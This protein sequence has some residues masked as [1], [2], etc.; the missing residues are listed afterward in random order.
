M[1]IPGNSFYNAGRP[2]FS[3]VGTA[4]KSEKNNA[5]VRTQLRKLS[6]TADSDDA[7]GAYLGMQ[8]TLMLRIREEQGKI[9]AYSEL[10]GRISYYTDLLRSG[11]GDRVY[12]DELKYD[13][14]ESDTP[15]IAR[16]RIES[17]LERSK[18]AL[19]RLVHWKPL[20]KTMEIMNRA[21]AENFKQAAAAFYGATGIDSELLD[22]T[23]DPSLLSHQEGVSQ[24]NF[25]KTAE[26]NIES[27]KARSNG[28]SEL[29]REY[30]EMME[31]DPED[32]FDEIKAMEKYLAAIAEATRQNFLLVGELND[33]NTARSLLDA[34][35]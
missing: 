20:N 5:A 6:R 35:A 1:R 2:M 23:D 25:I 24:E 27:L 28:L 10:D 33:A 22:I 14:A 8:K 12:A 19:D 34:M 16:S 29:M 4:K 32:P 15:F 7:T 30:K 13:L 21:L 3:V 26:K 18:D 9:D 31:A 11:S 17:Y